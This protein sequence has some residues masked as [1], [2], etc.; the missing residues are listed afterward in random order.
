MPSQRQEQVQRLLMEEIGDLIRREVDDPSIGFVTITGAEVSPDLRHARMYVSVLG[1]D[2]AQRQTMAGLRRARGFLRG[3][4]GRR[5]TLRYTPELS[6]EHDDTAAKAQRI[7]QL[8][9]E[10]GVA[11]E[12]RDPLDAGSD[13]TSDEEDPA[14]APRDPDPA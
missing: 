10:I 5:L 1:D 6:F 9:E 4:L 3:K 11:D 8:L 14:G 13:G 2:E 12:D 7:D